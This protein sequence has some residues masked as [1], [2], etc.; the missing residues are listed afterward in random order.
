VDD[1]DLE[2]CKDCQGTGE[3]MIERPVIDYAEGGYLKT[4]QYKCD[5]CDGSGWIIKENQ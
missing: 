1:V 3:V 5:E 2:D 4:Y